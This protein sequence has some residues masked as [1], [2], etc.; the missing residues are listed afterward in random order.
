MKPLPIA[1]NHDP[2]ALARLCRAAGIELLILF[3]SQASGTVH[4]ASDLDLAVT[5]ERDRAPSRLQLIY[6]LETIFHPH[7]VDLVILT[8]DTSP[9]L[10]H[11]AFFRGRPLYESCDGLFERG[12]LRAWKL[13]LDTARLR[14]REAHYLKDF[15][16]RM[17]N[18]VA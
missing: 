15:V 10:L 13:Y 17:R 4:A 18:D 12:R 1:M 3:G 14:T 16:R 8:R 11:E 6:D 9:L 5:F 2:A 7:S